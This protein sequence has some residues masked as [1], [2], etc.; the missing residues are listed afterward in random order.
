MEEKEEQW[1]TFQEPIAV[2]S[3]VQ[4]PRPQPASS[5][6]SQNL[7][8]LSPAKVDTTT[9]VEALEVGVRGQI[10]GQSSPVTMA[11]DRV[12]SGAECDQVRSQGCSHSHEG[13]T[14][15]SVSKSGI[16]NLGWGEK[17]SCLVIIVSHSRSRRECR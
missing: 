5:A 3:S 13:T 16:Y 15:V 2:T 9:S 12:A 7:S 4:M 11:T 8:L 17:V 14:G 1:L 6:P 10:L